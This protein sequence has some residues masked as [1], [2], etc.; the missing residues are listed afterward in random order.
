M[1][2]ASGCP[3]PWRHGTITLPQL[4]LDFSTAL[5]GTVGL[6]RDM[7]GRELK[8]VDFRTRKRCPQHQF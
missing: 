2:C 1:L 7:E 8:K 4:G 3:F 6:P 5:V